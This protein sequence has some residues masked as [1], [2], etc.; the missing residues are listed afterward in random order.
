MKKT[1]DAILLGEAKTICL[2][3]KKKT[4]G[5]RRGKKVTAKNTTTISHS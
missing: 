3:K 5:E 1:T 4:Q 2:G